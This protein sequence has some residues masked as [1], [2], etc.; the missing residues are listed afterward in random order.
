ML[1]IK[2]AGVG[3]PGDDDD[4]AGSHTTSSMADETED[5]G[6]ALS[7]VGSAG[8]DGGP[9][10]PPP[11]PPAPVGGGG[12]AAGADRP[13]GGRRGR[14]MSEKARHLLS[15]GDRAA[16]ERAKAALAEIQREKAELAA[17][18]AEAELQLN[19]HGEKLNLAQRKHVPLS[20]ALVAKEA[21][22]QRAED[23]LEARREELYEAKERERQMKLKAEAARK[24]AEE[25]KRGSKT[26][27]QE[28]LEAK[29][30]AEA[31]VRAEL[32]RSAAAMETA[33]AAAAAAEAQRAKEVGDMARK[34]AEMERKFQAVEEEKAELRDQMLRAEA[35]REA[36]AAAA[37]AEMEE[38]V[39]EAAA[40]AAA[41]AAAAAQMDAMLAASKAPA[42]AAKGAGGGGAGDGDNEAL[43]ATVAALKAQLRALGVED[44]DGWDGTLS[45]AQEM[46]RL[47]AKKLIAGDESYQGEFDKWERRVSMHPDTIAAKEAEAAEWRR[48]NM[49]LCAKALID[50][51]RF[52]P[53][54]IAKTTQVELVQVRAMPPSIVRRIF[55]KRSIWLVRMDPTNI[56]RLHHTDL[57]VQYTTQGLDLVELRAVFAAAPETFNND[58]DGKKAMWRE[59]M[60]DRLRE[61]GPV[62]C[63]RRGWCVCVWGGGL[64]S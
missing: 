61:V 13:G 18:V 43:K 33:R 8:G 58:P 19:A 32:E 45:S 56:A 38:T 31:D 52:V 10:P 17:K 9:P 5:G 21:A 22:A 35:D 4:E 25:H 48:V 3:S 37:R 24:D 60:F 16:D 39:A 40:Q 53:A 26:A 34:L 64:T 29:A 47:I 50:M 57:T 28:A 49:P 2:L 54:D 59:Q 46:M 41:Q 12:G 30:K 1:D 7:P 63:R 44:D 51:R 36:A 27:L 62:P 55:A 11:P 42:R 23:E 20:A 14:A 6:G 15:A